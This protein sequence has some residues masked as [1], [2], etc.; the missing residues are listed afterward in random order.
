[1]VDE[2]H[3]LSHEMF[4]EIRFLLNME[5]DSKSSCSLLLVEQT[6]L[7]SKLKLHIHQAIDGRVDMRFHLDAMDSEETAIYVK[8]HLD[9][10]NCP[11]EIFTEN[12]LKVIHDYSGGTP[13]K[14]N[15]V[16]QASL[17]AAASQKKQLIDDYLVRE[18]IMSELEV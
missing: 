11:R 1:V 2:A 12:A 4:E 7:R 6:E 10:V 13:R 15:K 9:R 5:M 17:M 16:A 14:V 8:R 3:L 18:V